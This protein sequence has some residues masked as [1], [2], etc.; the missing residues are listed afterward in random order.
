[1]CERTLQIKII[2]FFIGHKS[3]QNSNGMFYQAE[4]PLNEANDIWFHFNTFWK[5]TLQNCQ[6]QIPTKMSCLYKSNNQKDKVNLA[7]PSKLPRPHFMLFNFQSLRGDSIFIVCFTSSGIGQKQTH[8]VFFLIGRKKCDIFRNT[9]WLM[10]SMFCLKEN[11]F[12]KFQ[13]YLTAH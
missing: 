8:G 13:F 12:L 11:F 10:K 1:M 4:N 3:K 5:I 6:T 9:L 7:L 2:N